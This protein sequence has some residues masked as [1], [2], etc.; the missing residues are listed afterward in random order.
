MILDFEKNYIFQVVSERFQNGQVYARLYIGLFQKNKALTFANAL[1][2][3]LLSDIP[4]LLITNI[5]LFDVEHE[6]DPFPVIQETVFDVFENLKQII[7]APL[8]TDIYFSKLKPESF[9][10]FLQFQ[11]PGNIKAFDLKLPSDIFCVTPYQHI[12][13]IN[14]VNDFVMGIKIDLVF[15][16]K[17]NSTQETGIAQSPMHKIY[18]PIIKKNDQKKQIFHL[19]SF[20][21]PIKKVNFFIKKLEKNQDFEYIDLEIVTDGSIMPKQ[22]LRYSIL[23]LTQFFSQFLF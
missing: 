1:R 18:E 13:S 21:N 23:H 7:F 16:K 14:S 15:P 10:G 19:N 3:S 17:N 20:P 4:A 6:Y 9:Y 5:I 22:A 12:T 2:R 8:S 11:G